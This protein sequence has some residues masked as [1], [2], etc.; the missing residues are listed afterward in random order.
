MVEPG[1]IDAMNIVENT[2]EL[3]CEFPVLFSK[4]K[5][6]K[7]KSWYACVFTNKIVKSQQATQRIIYGYIDG[8]TANL[9]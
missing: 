1:Q 3:N 8:K 6:G 5:N 9:L 7:M 2:M 4:D